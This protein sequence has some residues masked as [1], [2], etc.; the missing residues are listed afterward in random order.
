MKKSC[1]LKKLIFYTTL[2]VLFDSIKSRKNKNDNEKNL[3][4]LPSLAP[5]KVLEIEKKVEKEE[6]LEKEVKKEE[7]SPLL[8]KKFLLPSKIEEILFCGED[9]QRIMLLT[10]SGEVFHTKDFGN[11]WSKISTK[12]DSYHSHLN[13]N[14]ITMQQNPNNKNQVIFI[15]DNLENMITNDCGD[16]Y[17]QLNFGKKM[18]DILYHPLEK[19]I[20]CGLDNDNNFILSKDG[21]VTWKIVKENIQEYTFAKFSDNAYL[22]NKNRIFAILEKVNQK[23]ILQK[24]LVF[25]DNFF[26][27]THTILENVE[28]FKITQCCV[29]AKQVDGEM[30]ISD[31]WGFFYTFYDLTIEEL[32]EKNFSE[33]NIIDT[34]QYYNT[35]GSMS[36]NYKNYELNRL[37]KSDYFGAH[38]KILENDLVC[39]KKLG[40]CDFVPINSLNGIVFIN[41]YDK[42][43]IEASQNL[44]KSRQKRFNS[45]QSFQNIDDF[46]Q[47]YI[48]FNFGEKF[49]RLKAPEVN[50]M[51]RRILCQ[52]D[53][54][55]NLHLQSSIKGFSLPKSTKHAPGLI[56]A[57]GSIS[58]YL[59]EEEDTD[60][61]Y[62][63]LFISNN[64]GLDWK[65]IGRGRYLYEIL[66]YGSL[67]II[68]KKFTQSTYIQYSFDNG[69]TFNKLKISENPVEII[70]L[71]VNNENHLKKILI[72]S[73]T[74]K[75]FKKK[76]MVI[77]L[78][79]SNLHERECEHDKEDKERSDYEEWIPHTAE[80]NGCLDGR[81]VILIRKKP[82]RTCFNSNNFTMYYIKESC[83]CGHDDYH[84]DFGYARN[85]DGYCVKDLQIGGNLVSKQPPNCKDFY[86]VSDGYKRNSET[87][88]TGGVEHSEIKYY[89]GNKGWFSFIHL[90]HFPHFLGSFT[91]LFKFNTFFKVLLFLGLVAGIYYC[92]MNNYHHVAL[93]Y[94]E[95]F[96]G[97]IRN[98]RSYKK[99]PSNV[100]SELQQKKFVLDKQ[101][102]K[103]DSIFE[104]ED[105]QEEEKS[106]EQVNINN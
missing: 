86:F 92:F 62:M 47:T 14:V 45:V 94:I 106:L 34:K 82:D 12:F 40:F 39:E 15:D 77:T 61:F 51:G 73:K 74:P 100:Y 67:I 37:M 22:A 17:K 27:S 85:A 91:N 101:D 44:P 58:K 13:M 21:A 31:A 81:K 65:M 103:I 8:Q 38:F 66:D 16:D 2:Y 89:C 36:Y 50:H 42:S 63:G 30:K 88:C 32:D 28:F 72:S 53:C 20:V 104:D 70:A 76:N 83:K 52:E 87:F 60:E 49:T 18:K 102:R 33:F 23:N 5:K 4:K 90:P 54:F 26:N 9:L 48:S 35:F 98:L 80:E 99:N 68:A 78:D 46:K 10:R 29:Y 75:N 24:N 55:L 11:N 96:V 25:T 6:K 69:Q 1:I 84:C 79:F 93:D 3:N 7:F 97:K 19:N 41:R 43:Y 95:K 56:I 64:A 59:V 71:T 57:S 105:I